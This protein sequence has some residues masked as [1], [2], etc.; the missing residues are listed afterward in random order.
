VTLV[1]RDAGGSRQ[2]RTANQL[3]TDGVSNF[4]Y[5]N[6][7]NLVKAVRIADGLTWTYAYD[8]LNHLTGAQERATDGGSLLLQATYVYD[9]FGD[10][11][12]KDVYTASTNTT[13]VSR[14]AY[15]GQDVW[16]D[17][18]GTNTLQTRYLR[19]DA[20]DQLFARIGASGAAAWYL[21]D[22]LGS[23]RNLVDGSGNLQDTI[24]YDP[25][26]N[27]RSESNP[28]FGDRYK[29]TGRELDAETN[30]QYNRQRYYDSAHGRWLSQDPLGLAAG[31]AN[32]YRYAGNAPTDATDPS[33]LT[34]ASA[35]ADPSGGA[36]GGQPLPGLGASPG[37][38]GMGPLPLQLAEP[39]P[40]VWDASQPPAPMTFVPLPWDPTQ[41]PPVAQ[42]LADGHSSAGWGQGGPAVIELPVHWNPSQP[43]PV[44]EILPGTW[45]PSQP[46]PEVVQLAYE[47]AQA[48]PWQGTWEQW[49]NSPVI[50]TLP[51]TWD[52]S[53][54]PPEAAQ[55]GYEQA[56][57][58]PW[59]GAWDGSSPPLPVQAL[60]GYWDGSQPPPAPA[61]YETASTVTL[62]WQGTWDQLSRP[63]TVSAGP[64]VSS[65]GAPDP[66]PGIFYDTA[67]QWH[68]L[69][70]ASFRAGTGTGA[71]ID[72]AFAA[73][74]RPADGSAID[75]GFTVAARP[76][77]VITSDPGCLQAGPSAPAPDPGAAPEAL[78]AAA[79]GNPPGLA[80]GLGLAVAGLG[81][82]A[83]GAPPGDV[84]DPGLRPHIFHG[85]GRPPAPETWD[86][87]LGH[88]TGLQ[89]LTDQLG[90]AVAAGPAGGGESLGGENGQQM[91]AGMGLIGTLW[92]IDTADPDP[93]THLL[94]AGCLA[95]GTLMISYIATHPT[96]P[97]LYA[98]TPSD[99]NAG[100]QGDAQNPVGSQAGAP[101]NGGNAGNLKPI[102]PAGEGIDVEALKPDFAFGQAGE[103]NLAVDAN[104]QVVLVPVR[105][106]THPNIPTGLSLEQAAELYPH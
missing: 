50:Q 96:G 34:G 90:H 62:T 105:P 65:F 17:L 95:V 24:T 15:D 97:H 45:D 52:P 16:A 9:V 27:V 99:G 81:A 59:Q 70:D 60:P 2:A 44:I 10:R 14:Y 92:I 28:G 51:D 106:G 38:G 80:T 56:Q 61:V 30:L 32:L 100:A 69:P 39:V 6:E 53:Q 42:E 23:V 8:N 7:G 78:L 55:M 31:D 63:V 46:P 40:Y 72:Q 91:A 104:G 68:V 47:Q 11:I 1:S 89:W 67:S 85:S 77:N 86:A 43:P 73:L 21:T 79:H 98:S 83:T 75:P 57:V 25:Y 13:T 87:W 29:Y 18:D 82:P 74:P 66:S 37:E 102:N 20:T 103:F 22:D 71:S 4:S 12:E 48:L 84:A 101:N 36:G 3:Q 64:A 94:G 49:A 19:G 54:P 5:D 33:G 35:Q 58:L 93:Y 88:M 76:G 26:G 41:P